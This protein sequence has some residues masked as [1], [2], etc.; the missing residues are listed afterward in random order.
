MGREQMRNLETNKIGGSQ[1][2]EFDQKRK[3]GQHPDEGTGGAKR[4]SQ[5]ERV[6]QIMAEAHKK[7]EKRRKKEAAK[8]GRSDKTT[9]TTKPD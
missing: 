9:T 2:N 1:G 4:L 5:A 6:E 7:V 8:A 3:L